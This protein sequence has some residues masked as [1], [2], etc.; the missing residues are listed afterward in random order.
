LFPFFDYTQDYEYL[1]HQD[2]GPSEDS[3][4]SWHL[5]EEEKGEDDSVNRLQKMDHAGCLR[6]Y[7][8][9][10]FYEKGV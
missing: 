8:L 6:F 3:A 2:D 10:A 5:A 7:L 1:T 9:H 4:Q